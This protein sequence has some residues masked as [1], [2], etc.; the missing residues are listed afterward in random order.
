MAKKKYTPNISQKTHTPEKGGWSEG[1]CTKSFPLY[2][3]NTCAKNC[4]LELCS[5]PAK[6]KLYVSFIWEVLFQFHIEFFFQLT[7]PKLAFMFLQ[8]FYMSLNA[9]PLSC[10][11]SFASHGDG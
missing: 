7:F 8:A 3:Y 10:L 9:S 5:F 11:L 6:Q 1:I 2:P 4:D